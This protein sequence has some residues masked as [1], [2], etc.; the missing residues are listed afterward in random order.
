MGLTGEK[1]DSTAA[2]AAALVLVG[3]AVPD[4]VMAALM[5]SDPGPQIPV[6]KL[7]WAI[8]HGIERGSRVVDVIST[9]AVRDFPASDWLWSG[10]RKWDRGNGSDNRLVPFINILGLKQLTRFVG[11]AVLLV[12]WAAA[13]RTRR[14]QV[15]LYGLMSPHLWAVRLVRRL[16]GMTMTVLITDLPGL[17]AAQESWW[18]RALRPIDRAMVRSAVQSADGIVVLTRQIAE[19]YAPDVPA[20]VMEGIVSVESEALASIAPKAGGQPQEFVV[21]YAGQLARVF[22]IQLMIDAV[23]AMPEADVRLWLLGD[24][25]MRDD[26]R[27]RAEADPRIWCPGMVAPAEAFRLSQLATVLI[28]PRPASAGFAPYSFPSKLLEYMAAGRPVATTRLPG[29]PPEYDPYLIWIDDETPEGL[30]ALLR[31]LRTRSRHDLDVLGRRGRDF[32]LREKN[33]RRQGERIAEFIARIQVRAASER[34]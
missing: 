16:F 9:V 33:Y 21:L 5:Q 2:A 22:G 19:D 27:R 25:D 34:D 8:I 28:N 29:I 6:Q 10:Y 13:R 7:S 12:R 1:H 17:A 15:L 3:A 14:R 31:Q 4:D 30:A 20:I 32:V 23:A 11:C 26:I 18:R 24:G